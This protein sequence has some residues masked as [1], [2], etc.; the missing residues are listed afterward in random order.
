MTQTAITIAPLDP[1]S[2]TDEEFVELNALGNRI[3]A[4]R[5]PDDPPL[6]VDVTRAEMLNH[7]PDIVAAYITARDSDGAVVGR[8]ATGIA[9]EGENIHLCHMGIDVLPE[10]RRRGIGSR[11]LAELVAF[12][13][14]NDRSVLLAHTTAR[15][16]AGAAFLERIGGRVVVEGNVNQLMLSELDR[17]QLARWIAAGEATPDYALEWLDGPVPEERLE[18]MAGVFELMNDQPFDDADINDE[19]FTADRVREYNKAMVAQGGERWIALVRHVP[20]GHAAGFTETMWHPANPAR[21]GQGGTAVDPKHRGHRLGKWLKAA[22]IERVLRE[23]PEVRFIRTGNAN[24][25][26]PMLAINDQLGFRSY[27]ASA[28]WQVDVAAA[29]AYVDGKSFDG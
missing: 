24:S 18:E 23:R 19:H 4:E 15:V 1:H 5:S 10:H 3:R 25:N 14:A 8:V 22:M 16:P 28:M 6:P 20:S 27:D 21:L 12:A 17:D 11:L 13:E 9:T 26:A 7:P 2:A 29:R